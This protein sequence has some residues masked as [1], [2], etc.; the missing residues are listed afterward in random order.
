MA[1][2]KKDAIDLEENRFGLFMT[3]NS[4]DTDVTLLQHY[5]KADVNY[6]I[7]IHKINVIESVT[8]KLYK[9]TKS[10]NKK[11]FPAVEVSCLIDIGD[12]EQKNLAEGGIV[13]D[14]V[15]N[16]VVRVLLKELEQKQ[17][18]ILRGDIIEYNVS[19][20]KSRF[21]EV[22]DAQNVVDASSQ[23]MANFKPFWKKIISVPVK[24]DVVPFLNET[25]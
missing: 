17:I 9:Q 12:V 10:H 6:K 3:D 22:E 14:D 21:Y 1:K 23:M 24:E 13:R 2:K 19:G 5:L 4:F 8:H 20:K 11:F 18:E 7:K 15:S 16:L 25:N